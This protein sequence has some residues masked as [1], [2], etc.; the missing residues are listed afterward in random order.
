MKDLAT[1]NLKLRQTGGFSGMPLDLLYHLTL[2]VSPCVGRSIV[3]PRT[4]FILNKVPAS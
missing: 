1:F 4:L 2:F 3:L